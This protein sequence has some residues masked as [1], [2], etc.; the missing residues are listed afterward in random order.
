[1]PTIKNLKLP[2]SSEVEVS[3]SEFLFRCSK[4]EKDNLF[5]MLLNLGYG[6]PQKRTVRRRSSRTP[7]KSIPHQEF[8]DACYALARNYHNISSES[9]ETVKSLASRFL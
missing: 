1:M 7:N 2:S 4:E 9:E 5:V 8:A 3:P 6:I